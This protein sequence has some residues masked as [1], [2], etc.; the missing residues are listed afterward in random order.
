MARQLARFEVAD[1]PTVWQVAGHVVLGQGQVSDFV[2]D[3]VVTP[4]GGRMDRQYLLHPGAVGVIAW[5][6]QDLSLIH[7]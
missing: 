3:T 4:D 6:A 7:I 5:D 1:A 2:N